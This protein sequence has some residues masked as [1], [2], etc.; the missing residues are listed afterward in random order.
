MKTKSKIT[1]SIDKDLKI[2]LDK[3]CNHN[4]INKSKLVNNIIKNFLNNVNK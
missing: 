1:L 3:Y 2:L 4:F